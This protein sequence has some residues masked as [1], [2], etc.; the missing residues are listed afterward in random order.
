M[1]Y[2]L[3]FLLTCACA[4]SK[5]PELLIVGAEPAEPA[6]SEVILEAKLDRI[7]GVLDSMVKDRELI[8][9]QIRQSRE[10]N[11]AC[12]K[13]FP[14]DPEDESNKDDRDNCFD[15]CPEWPEGEEC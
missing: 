11:Q 13:K 14:Y 15:S 7:Q 5:P 12:D 6:A 10:C 4:S 3:L 2:A 9:Y 8:R 1:R